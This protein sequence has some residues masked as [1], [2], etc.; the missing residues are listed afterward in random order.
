MHRGSP[1]DLIDT[2]TWR[3]GRTGS[4]ER[5]LLS[6]YREHGETGFRLLCRM[7][8]DEASARDL[9]HDT[10]VRVFEHWDQYAGHG[11]A[12]SWICRIA[13]NLARDRSSRFR[14][15]NNAS[16]ATA[17]YYGTGP[18]RDLV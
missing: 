7:T 17:T 8:G 6:L 4:G 18:G 11:S 5:N 13:A 2:E 3:L 16:A 1:E 12:A 9:T 14:R 15:R 10:F